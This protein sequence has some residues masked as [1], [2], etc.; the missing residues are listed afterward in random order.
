MLRERGSEVV[1]GHFDRAW[2]DRIPASLQDRF[3]RCMDDFDRYHRDS[4]Y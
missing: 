3:D 1:T 4:P 2:R